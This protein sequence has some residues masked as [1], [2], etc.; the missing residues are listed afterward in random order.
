MHRTFCFRQT[1][2]LSCEWLWFRGMFRNW[3]FR[4]SSPELLMAGTKKKKLK[5]KHPCIVDTV[6]TVVILW[7]HEHSALAQVRG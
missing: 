5:C 1:L 6:L 2:L 3:A 4:Y 7:L